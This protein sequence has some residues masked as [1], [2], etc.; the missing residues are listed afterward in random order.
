MPGVY[1]LEAGARI[2]QAVVLAGGVRE[3]AAEEFVNQA[4]QLQDGERIYIPTEEEI[5]QGAAEVTTGNPGIGEY[6][7]GKYARRRESEFEYGF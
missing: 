5:R 3:D 7:S 1:E 2:Y 4:Q 6:E